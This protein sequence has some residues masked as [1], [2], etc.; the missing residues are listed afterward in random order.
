[1]GLARE[2]TG[3][4]RP[5]TW[6]YTDKVKRYPYDPEKAKAAPRR[7]GLEGQERR[8]HPARQ[9][10]QAVHLHHPD[11]PGQRRAEEDRRDHPAAPQGD[12]RPDGHPDHRVGRLHQ[13]VHQAEALRGGRPRLGH[14]HRPRPVRGLALLADGARTS[15]TRS[16]TPTRR[17]TALLEEGRASCHQEERVAVLPPDPGDPGRGPADHLPLLPGRAAGGGVA[18]PRHRARPRRASSTT[19]SSGSCRSTCSAIRPARWRS[20]PSA[21]CCSRSRC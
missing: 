20:S 6:A 17:W 9:G 14:R 10:R 2:A 5:G 3:P 8:R 21:G 1:M 18:R 19:S 16:R 13:G 7:G 15:S 4:I 12:R 11:Q